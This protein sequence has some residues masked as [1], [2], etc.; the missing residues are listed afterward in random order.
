MGE[1]LFP[2][3]KEFIDLNGASSRVVWMPGV[4]IA[5]VISISV[6]MHAWEREDAG[7]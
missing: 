7:L 3:H 5:S 6:D 2:K 1:S 4:N